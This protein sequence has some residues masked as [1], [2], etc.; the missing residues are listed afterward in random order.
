MKKIC[1]YF[2]K[3]FGYLWAGYKKRPWLIGSIFIIALIV[4]IS[5]IAR[6]TRPEAVLNMLSDSYR[7]EAICHEACMVRRREFSNELIVALRADPDLKIARL[8]R[9]GFLEEKNNTDLRIN[10]L[11]IIRQANSSDEAPEFLKDYL[12]KGGNDRLKA[13]ILTSYRPA[14]LSAEVEVDPLDYY[15][16]ILAGNDS[17]DFKLAAIK[18]LSSFPDKDDY[19]SG[20]QLELVR[21]LILNSGTDKRLR[22]PL[23]LLLS[24][25]YLVFPE[26]T[27]NILMAYYLTAASGDTISRAF[28]ADSLNRLSGKAL[29]APE[30][31]AQE[32]DEY[33]SN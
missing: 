1:G 16:K 4:V 20:G 33:Y 25:Y 28:A 32:W 21:G 7:S 10:L 22:Q 11:S 12:T 29:V 27:E 19:L 23:I 9:S 17:L 30:I 26:E 15:Y 3:T 14:A 8:F 13:E 18:S 2:K 24:D 5:F 31:S 6:P